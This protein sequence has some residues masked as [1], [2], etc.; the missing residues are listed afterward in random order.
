MVHRFA[1]LGKDIEATSPPQ[2]VARLRPLPRQ[3]KDFSRTQLS[4]LT[5]SFPWRIVIVIASQRL[6]KE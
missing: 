4:Q 5:N 1:K 2:R 3:F 6:P